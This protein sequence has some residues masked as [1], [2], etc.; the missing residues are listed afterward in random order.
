VE[1]DLMGSM[2]YRRMIARNHLDGGYD[3][4]GQYPDSVGA[5]QWGHM[6]DPPIIR[7]PNAEAVP[8]RNHLAGDLRR[9]ETDQRDLRHLKQYADRTGLTEGQVKAVLDLFFE[10]AF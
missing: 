9:L 10:G 8:S 1:F 2:N 7:D 3:G 4:I 5:P 6:V